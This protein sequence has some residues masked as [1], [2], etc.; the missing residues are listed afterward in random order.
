MR[1]CLSLSELLMIDQEC[2]D[3]VTTTVLSIAHLVFLCEYATVNTALNILNVIILLC[4]Q[5][6]LSLKRSGP[7]QNG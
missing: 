4:I 2:A 7:L 5:Y 3:E 6:G 1:E